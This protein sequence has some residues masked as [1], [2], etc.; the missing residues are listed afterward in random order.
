MIY[1]KLW[2][3]KLFKNEDLGVYKHNDIK[4][5]KVFYKRIKNINWTLKNTKK[6]YLKITLEV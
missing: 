1:E 2:K 5:K 3:S 6:Y 4:T